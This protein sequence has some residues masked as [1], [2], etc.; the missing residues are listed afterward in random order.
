MKLKPVGFP[1]FRFDRASPKWMFKA[2]P[3][4]PSSGSEQF[5]L[6]YGKNEPSIPFPISNNTNP[7]SLSP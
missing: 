2:F 5:R 1:E 4:E 7:N 3:K 6:G